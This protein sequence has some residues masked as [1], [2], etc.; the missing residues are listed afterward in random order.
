L[1]GMIIE[2]QEKAVGAK[3]KYEAAIKELI[4]AIRRSE[5]PVRNLQDS[6][7]AIS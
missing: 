3:E 2:G 6:V 7:I 1:E 5:K 4:A